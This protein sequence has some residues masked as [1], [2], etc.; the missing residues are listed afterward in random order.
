MEREID[1]ADRRCSRHPLASGPNPSQSRRA[2]RSL[3]KR[4]P[5]SVI[6]QKS[7]LSSPSPPLG[8]MLAPVQWVFRV[9]RVYEDRSTVLFKPSLLS[10]NAFRVYLLYLLYA[11][12]RRSWKAIG[13]W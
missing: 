12:G 4:A 8:S 6:G 7:G 10:R 3:I 13:K 2:Q 9:D 5:V 11:S 1:V